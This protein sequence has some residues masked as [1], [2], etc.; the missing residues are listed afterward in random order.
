MSNTK[1]DNMRKNNFLLCV[2]KNRLL[3]H[4]LEETELTFLDIDMTIH[5]NEIFREHDYICL[6]NQVKNLKE[7]YKETENIISK[8]LTVYIIKPQEW[9]K[10]MEIN[11]KLIGDNL[12]KRYSYDLDICDITIMIYKDLLDFH[13]QLVKFGSFKGIKFNTAF[14]DWDFSKNERTLIPIVI[15]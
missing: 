14:V 9:D 7:F 15:G 6:A 2:L 8:L 12:S 3:K 13:S 5:S 10:I 1:L 11:Q 4:H